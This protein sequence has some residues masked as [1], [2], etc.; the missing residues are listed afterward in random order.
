MEPYP[1][2]ATRHARAPAPPAPAARG[3]SGFWLM[4]LGLL[5]LAASVTVAGISFHPLSRP[6]GA[7]PGGDDAGRR[8]PVAVAYVD[9]EGGVRPLYP[10]VPGRVV[11]APVPEGK[12]VPEGTVLLRIDDSLARARLREAK[13]ELEAA[14]ERL[15]QAKK[16]ISQ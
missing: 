7:D 5:S 14:R 13:V 9:V 4:T 11:E 8:H 16:L 6:A 12:E 15:A 10:A 2:L 3:R 1:T